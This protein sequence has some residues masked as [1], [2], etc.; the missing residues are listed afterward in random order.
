M[1][2]SFLPKAI[3]GAALLATLTAVSHAQLL[4]FDSLP[5][6][7]GIPNGYGGL[8]W[9]NFDVLDKS[10]HPGSGYDHGTVSLRNVAFNSFGDPASVS[11]LA[12][13]NFT[14]LYLTAAWNDG[15]SVKIDG[16]F[17]GTLL[18]TETLVVNTNAPTFE[19]LNY[20]GVNEVR[21]ESFGGLQNQSLGGSGTH[22]AIDNVQLN[23]ASP[24][25]EPSTYGLIGAAGLIA[26]V[27]LRRRKLKE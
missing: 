1:F 21:F 18:Y 3:F 13:F 9:T 20:I 6:L 17:N 27:A 12:R 15:L 23:G 14:S 25:P 7:N 26:L 11:A 8:N 2:K 5:S 19:L 16:L 4:T 24:V 10:Y 22:F